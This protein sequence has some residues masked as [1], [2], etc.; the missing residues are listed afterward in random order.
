LVDSTDLDRECAQI[1]DVGGGRSTL[2]DDLLT[3]DYRNLTVL[4]KYSL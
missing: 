4:Q 2:V 3:N 1:I